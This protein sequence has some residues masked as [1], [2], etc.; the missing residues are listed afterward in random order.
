MPAPSAADEAGAQHELVAHDLG[1]GGSF[2][3]GVDR[4][5]REDPGRPRRR[6][7]SLHRGIIS[8]RQLPDILTEQIAHFFTHYK[9]LEKGKWSKVGAGPKPRKPTR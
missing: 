8:Y 2:L 7:A 5:R 3:E 6:P 4:I 9:D 1:I